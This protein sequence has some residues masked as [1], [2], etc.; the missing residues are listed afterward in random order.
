MPW[1]RVLGTERTLEGFGEFFGESALRAGISGARSLARRPLGSRG[2]GSRSILGAGRLCTDGPTLVWNRGTP[3]RSKFAGGRTTGPACHPLGLGRLSG[4]GAKEPIFEWR[5]VKALDD[6]LQFV[7]VRSFDKSEA[8][9]LL[10]FRIP[11]DLDMVGDE[12]LGRQPG[13]DVVCGHPGR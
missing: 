2:I 12:I 5:S 6:R 13:L 7:L 11:D 3:P 10:C 4:I 9:G 1:S 8:L